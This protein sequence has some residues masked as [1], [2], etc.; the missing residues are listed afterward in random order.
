ME[1]GRGGVGKEE[2]AEERGQKRRKER[3]SKTNTK[4]WNARAAEI[5]MSVS[6][7]STCCHSLSRPCFEVGT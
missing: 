3:K 2:E 5:F 1:G 7:V 6:I 4:M